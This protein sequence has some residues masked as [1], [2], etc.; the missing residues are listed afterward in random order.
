M[1]AR[2]PDAVDAWLY[3][4]YLPGG[5]APARQIYDCGQWCAEE[6]PFVCNG[7]CSDEDPGAQA[8]CDQ[9]CPGFRELRMCGDEC[10]AQCQG[11]VCLDE[12]RSESQCQAACGNP[13][14]W[15]ANIGGGG[16]RAEPPWPGF[17]NGYPAVQANGEPPV[18]R[19][20]LSS[21]LRSSVP[22]RS[23]QRSSTRF[24]VLPV[25]SSSRVVAA[26]SLSS[27]VASSVASSVTPQA[28]PEAEMPASEMHLAPVS[29]EPGSFPWWLLFLLV[30]IVSGGLWFWL[31]RRASSD[32]KDDANPS[33]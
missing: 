17:P 9:L 25:A 18:V 15:N 7:W 5:E 16:M 6:Y 28:L 23:S 32:A 31:S 29:E 30:L 27:S 4:P 22:A 3:R 12:F 2:N 13:D 21:S 1:D 8:A 14:L 10:L 11:A 33:V 24:T 19:Q 26:S 20:A